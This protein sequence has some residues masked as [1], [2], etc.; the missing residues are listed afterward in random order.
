MNG[1]TRWNPF[2]E[3]DELQ[4][5]LNSFFNLEPSRGHQD[6]Y[7]VETRWQPL[8]DIAEDDKEYVLKLELPEV[9]RED[10]KITVEN[11]VLTVAGER[12]FEKDEKGRKHHRI[13]RIYGSFARSFTLPEDADDSKVTADFKDGLLSVHL[14]KNEK[15]KPKTIEVKVA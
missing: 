3:M 9:R 2:R 11:G 4:R 6:N 5:R 8:V 1:L 12:K 13:E 10:V 15:A 7:Q 14:V